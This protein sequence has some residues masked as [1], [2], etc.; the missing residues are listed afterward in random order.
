MN[1]NTKIILGVAIIGVGAY[2]IMQNYKSQKKQNQFLGL[3]SK[4]RNRKRNLTD[5]KTIVNKDSGWLRANGQEF[6]DVSSSGFNFTGGK[7]FF[8]VKS[9]TL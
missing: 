3:G 4:N 5:Y 8:D 7:E 6:F 9:T 1:K 2:M